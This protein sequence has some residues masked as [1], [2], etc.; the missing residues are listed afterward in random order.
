MEIKILSAVLLLIIGFWVILKKSFLDD[1]ENRGETITVPRNDIANAEIE[2]NQIYGSV[3][4]KVKDL[5]NDILVGEF[6]GGVKHDLVTVGENAFVKIVPHNRK[7]TIT[8]FNKKNNNWLFFLD[9]H[10]TYTL[11]KIQGVNSSVFVDTRGAIVKKFSCKF[12]KG[13][14][15]II[16][17]EKFRDSL[18]S[19]VNIETLSSKLKV[20]LPEEVKAEITLNDEKSLVQIDLEKFKH[21]PGEKVYQSIGFEDANEKVY[22]RIDSKYSLIEIL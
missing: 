16:I 21:L 14:A 9:N 19:T 5:E 4:I 13:N 8:G 15:Q 17:S 11:L 2:I 12:N 20:V 22:V 7:K 10:V 6:L 1:G 3:E 18:N